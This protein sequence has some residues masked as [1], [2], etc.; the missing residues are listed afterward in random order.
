MNIKMLFFTLNLIE[1]LIIERN[2]IS[3]YAHNLID[4]K[5]RTFL[6]GYAKSYQGHS[7][8]TLHCHHQQLQY[9]QQ[10]LIKSRH[11]MMSNHITEVNR[12]FM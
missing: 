9:P 3:E 5:S 12:Y 1:S 10:T 4:D 8:Q 11:P 7:H 2:P 6:P